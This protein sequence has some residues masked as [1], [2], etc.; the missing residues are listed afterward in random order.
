MITA[1]TKNRFVSLECI[2]CHTEYPVDTHSRCSKCSGILTGKY[3]LGGKFFDLTMRGDSVWQFA[4]VMPY[5]PDSEVV[6]MGE[7]WT[8]LVR[9]KRLGDALGMP[10]L[11]CKIEGE[12]PS[13][14]FK[15]RA[16]SLGLSLAKSW[17]NP[18]VFTASSGNAAAAI[19]AY[20]ARA[21]LDCLVMVREDSTP[22]KL[23]QIAM[24]GPKLLRVRG[25]FSSQGSLLEA[26]EMVQSAL[27][28]WLNHFVW[29]PFN[30]LLIDG[31]KT[32]AYEIASQSAKNA[33]P[34][35][36]VVPTAGGDLLYG[37]YKG[38]Q[39]LKATGSVNRI[40]KMVV[41]QGLNASPTVS[42][43]ESNSDHIV[44]IDSAETVAGALR[45]S[46]SADHAVIAVRNSGGFGVGVTDEEILKAQRDVASADG[47]FTEVSSATA[48]A[49]V[50][51]SLATGKIQKDEKVIAI[52]TGSGFKDYSPPFKD[53]SQVPL[54]EKI[55]AIP[56]V[57]KL[58]LSL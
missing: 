30:P 6:S 22:S 48:L 24:Y 54:A 47:I 32:V 40:P 12:N 36:I 51:R 14:S 1:Q 50:R 41:A 15:D 37:I 52:L 58:D 39:E 56:S 55:D 44:E 34:D 27:P 21:G 4:D 43:L 18:G 16:A 35:Y 28:K 53:V 31:L 20:S 49:A 7:G 29:A 25:V 8:P 57:L 45:V 38:F 26:L 19:S 23:G 2:S 17:G 46:F 3:E 9:A 10:E 42:A 13:G 11:W 5:V 33:L